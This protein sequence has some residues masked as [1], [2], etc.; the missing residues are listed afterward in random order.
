M[1]VAMTMGLVGSDDRSHA[2]R[3]SRRVKTV[4]RELAGCAWAFPNLVPSLV[5]WTHFYHV[6]LKGSVCAPGCHNMTS[7]TGED[8][9]YRA[10][11]ADTIS[12]TRFLKKQ[13]T[14]TTTPR[15]HACKSSLRYFSPWLL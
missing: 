7:P 5:T 9:P 4:G 12:R 10:Y 8:R 11:L 3:C 1:V 15:K 6:Y 13:R 2:L 14:I